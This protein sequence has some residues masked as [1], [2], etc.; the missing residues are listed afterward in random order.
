MRQEGCVIC[1]STTPDTIPPVAVPKNIFSDS[2]KELLLTL[3]NSSDE[4]LISALSSEEKIGF[5][6]TEGDVAASFLY[7]RGF[8]FEP[9][10]QTFSAWPMPVFLI[11]PERN[12]QEESLSLELP[13]LSGLTFP[14]RISLQEYFNSKQAPYRLD[15]V[16]HYCSEKEDFPLAEAALSQRSDVRLWL[17]L[18][19]LWHLSKEE[20]WKAV[21]AMKKE[22]IMRTPS[23]HMSVDELCFLFEKRIPSFLAKALVEDHLDACIALEDETLVK[24]LDSLQEYPK[25]R[26]RLCIKLIQV[27]RKEN[28]HQLAKKIVSELA[29]DPKIESMSVHE[30]IAYF[31]APRETHPPV[32][33][34]PPLTT[35]ASIMETKTVANKVES[36][37]GEPKPAQTQVKWT[38]Y[39]VQK[40]DTI[41]KI[42]Q[43]YKVDP[44]KISSFNNLKKGQI[45]IGQKLRIPSP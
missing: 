21:L 38:L 37:K 32:S 13:L 3:K 8:D 14:M 2:G 31:K 23:E 22:A 26:A 5:G 33:A 12:E 1:L 29:Q 41:W 4:A 45:D 19:Q 36:K 9:V 44:N 35:K 20:S 42:A 17:S 24:L 25:I 15:Y 30:L 18:Y 34:Q 43:K 27:P 7:M 28:I 39:T 11:S 6:Y 16:L 40:G 10:L